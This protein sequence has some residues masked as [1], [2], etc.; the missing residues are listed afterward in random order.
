[1]VTQRDPE[2]YLFSVSVA[3]SVAAVEEY[4]DQVIETLLP[5]ALDLAY[6]T[7]PE[8][9]RNDPEGKKLAEE[10]AREYIQDMID[11]GQTMVLNHG[12]VGVVNAGE[13]FLYRDGSWTDETKLIETTYNDGSG[14]YTFDNY[15]IK[16]YS[17]ELERPFADVEPGEWYFEA[18]TWAKGNGVMHGYGDGTTFGPEDVLTREQAAVVLWNAIGG[19]EVV[20]SRGMS[21]VDEGEWYADAVNWCVANHVMDGYGGGVFGVGDVLTREQLACTVAKAVGGTASDPGAAAGLPDAGEVSDWAADGVAWAVENG[22]IAG[23]E[24]DGGRELQPQGEVTRGQMAA[25]IMNAVRE[26]VLELK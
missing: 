20:G 13:S 18:A 25:I 8:W 12:T 14:I 2:A 5:D 15:T 17:D 3:D 16:A 7:H 26:D 19:G 21:D 24:V 1:M 6:T 4:N 9:D 10:F 22:V 23:V 11:A